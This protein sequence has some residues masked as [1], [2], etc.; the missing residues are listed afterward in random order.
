MIAVAV[1]KIRSKNLKCHRRSHEKSNLSIHAG[2]LISDQL[3]VRSIPDTF[4]EVFLSPDT[5][6][7][8]DPYTYTLEKLVEQV[9]LASWKSSQS[10]SSISS[11][12]SSPA[13]ATDITG[14]TGEGMTAGPS[15]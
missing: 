6:D 13:D 2:T 10:D 3:I 14:A 5:L 11:T 12:F 9:D 4:Y 15:D 7:S 1:Q 8:P